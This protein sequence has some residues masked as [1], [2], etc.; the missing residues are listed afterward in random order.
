MRVLGITG[1]S[2]NG[3]TTLI[4]ALLPALRAAGLSVSTIKHAHHGFDIDRPGKDSFR[5]REAGASEVLVATAERWALLHEN[6]GA[7][8]SLTALLARLAPVDLVLVEG[9]KREACAK[10]EVHRPAV[11][12]PAQW[13]DDPSI[14][15]VASDVGLPHCDRTVLPLGQPAAVAAWLLAVLQ[16]LPV[17]G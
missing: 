15:A 4:V 12:K 17:V 7:E 13:P 5:H 3:K 10:L 2:G 9:Y 14:L 16:T 11:G 8:P 1:G 6:D